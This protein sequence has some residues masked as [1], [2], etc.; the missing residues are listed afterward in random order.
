MRQAGLKHDS[1]ARILGG[2]VLQLVLAG[3]HLDIDR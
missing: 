3:Y 1:A 2:T